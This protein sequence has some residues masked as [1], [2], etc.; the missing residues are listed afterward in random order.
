[1]W[2]GTRV[3]WDTAGP[4]W[5]ATLASYGVL[6][7]PRLEGISRVASWVCHN[8]SVKPDNWGISS[9]SV[10]RQHRLHRV[11]DALALTCLGLH[12]LVSHMH[13]TRLASHLFR[14]WLTLVFALTRSST[15]FCLLS[16]EEKLAEL[17]SL[18]CRSEQWPSVL[19]QQPEY[20][21]QLSLCFLT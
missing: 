9:F 15:T 8:S 14:R 13:L 5:R 11:D 17:G 10:S 19:V 6:L 3:D 20:Q 12:D 16:L 18:T 21:S 7:L 1:M 2:L 4:P